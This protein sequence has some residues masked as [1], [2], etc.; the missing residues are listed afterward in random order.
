MVLASR[1]AMKRIRQVLYAT[2]FSPT[3]RRARD[4]AIGLAKL[5]HA[6]ITILFVLAPVILVPGQ[7]VDAETMLALENRARELGKQELAVLA[8]RARKAGV[9]AAVL[10][11]EGDP[12]DQ[13]VRVAR[14][15]K[16]DFIVMGTHG[17]RGLPKLFLGSVAG[18]VVTAAPCPVVTVRGK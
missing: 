7:Y 16:A 9:R 12:P 10:L 2:D 3:S 5:G 6:R 11:R 15:T 8:T 18:R 17:R 4:T 13:I 1:I 14:S